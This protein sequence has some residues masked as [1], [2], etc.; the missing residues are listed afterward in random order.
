MNDIVSSTDVPSVDALRELIAARYREPSVAAPNG[1]NQTLETILSHRSVRAYLPDRLPPNTIELLVAAA[2]SSP[3]SSNLQAWSVI[4]VEDA[5]RKSRL[6]AFAGGQAHIVQCPLFLVWLADLARLH[7]VGAE[8]DRPVAAL[9]YIEAFILAVVDAALAAQNA[10]VALESLGLGSVYI[11]ALRNKPEAV[12][13]E[14]GLPS[15]VFALFGLCVGYPDPA[16]PTGV[17]PRLG[18]R[19]VLHREQYS[20]DAQRDTIRSYD[21]KIRE[22][23]AEQGM[24]LLDWTRQATARVAGPAALLGRDRLREALLGSGFGLR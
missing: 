23:Q 11:G 9:D 20:L 10:V 5:G 3:T 13:A 8:R 12:A 14:L 1:W 24:P 16:V 4:A 15:H 19:A 2:Q 17:K 6:A 18:Q 7:D 22:F 21:G